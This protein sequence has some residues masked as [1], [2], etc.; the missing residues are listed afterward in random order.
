MSESCERFRE[1]ALHRRN[2]RFR[3][4][5]YSKY[6]LK[7]DSLNSL[8]SHEN[9]KSGKC[10]DMLHEYEC[11]LKKEWEENEEWRGFLMDWIDKNKELLKL[12]SK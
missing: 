8:C 6:N 9:S 11:P 1:L 3:R 10:F 4:V 12:L 7:F 2:C 5:D